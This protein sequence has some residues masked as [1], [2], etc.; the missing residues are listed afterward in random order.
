[1]SA[2]RIAGGSENIRALGDFVKALVSG[3]S[4]GADSALDAIKLRDNEFGRGYM[5]ALT[6]MR[7]S[8]FGDNVD[9]LIFKILKGGMLAKERTSVQREFR[10]RRKIPFAPDFE[11]GYSAAWKDVLRLVD[12]ELKSS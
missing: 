6:G 2:K 7:S 4:R 8:L 11:K 5:K 1:M 9:S 10:E 3:D 12:Q